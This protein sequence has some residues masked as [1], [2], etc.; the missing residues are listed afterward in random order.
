MAATDLELI[1]PDWPAQVQVQAVSTT[2]IGGFSA[3]PYASLNLG[4]HVGDDPDIAERNRMFLVD[5]LDYGAT[6]R[7]LD[8]VHGT[9]VIVADQCV[10]HAA[11]DAA[12]TSESGIACAIMTA[13]C[14]PVI[15]TDRNGTQVAAAHAGWRGLAGG[16]IENTV[17]MFAQR[18]VSADE[19]LAWLG[20][21]IG[22]A[23]YEVDAAV[24]DSF[25][26]I[27]KSA[28]VQTDSAHW[29]LDLYELARLR[30]ASSGVKAVY[31]GG[32]C[33]HSDPERFF[34]YRRDGICGRQATLI[35]LE[36]AL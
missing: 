1:R 19:L 4:T 25:D 33:T 29:Q 28:A 2:R 23:A 36:Q 13:D 21:A 26:E 9:D 35:W 10:D 3:G 16:I 17:A 7:W 30:L 6:P 27:D 34:S 15:F 8:Q 11:A 18:G 31:G 12:I 5:A 20:P 14:L 22:S 32:L 24:V